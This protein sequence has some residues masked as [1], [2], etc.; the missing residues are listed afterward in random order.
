MLIVTNNNKHSITIE[1]KIIFFQLIIN[2]K[3]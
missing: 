3:P 2:M 1:L